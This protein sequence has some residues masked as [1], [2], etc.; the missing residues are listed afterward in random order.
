M[1]ELFYGKESTPITGIL[2][3]NENLLYKGA[4]T[5]KANVYSH[6]RS[7]ELD[8]SVTNISGLFAGRDDLINIPYIN[9]ANITNMENTFYGCFSL[10]SESFGKIANM[11]PNANQLTNQY[12]RNIGLYPDMFDMEQYN[13]LRDK[14]YNMSF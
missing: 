8:S 4:A 12:I 7:L 11:L 6:M 3:Y 13:I 14:G 1:V 5:A 2:N 10:S 9:L